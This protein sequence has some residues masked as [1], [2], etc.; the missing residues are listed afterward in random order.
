MIRGLEGPDGG[1]RQYLPPGRTAVRRRHESTRNVQQRKEKKSE[2]MKKALKV[3]ARC[4]FFPLIASRGLLWNPDTP[5]KASFREGG[6]GRGGRGGGGWGV[7]SV[8]MLLDPLGE[9]PAAPFIIKW[10]W[11]MKLRSIQLCTAWPGEMTFSLHSNKRSVMGGGAG[12]GGRW[13]SLRRTGG[14]FR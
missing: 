4:Y 3:F 12:E 14:T 6:G 9:Q 5:T 11:L 2:T 8:C 10:L 1:R 7:C 13:R